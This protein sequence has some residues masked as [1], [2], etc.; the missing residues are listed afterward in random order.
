MKRFG[1]FFVAILLTLGLLFNQCSQQE[2]MNPVKEEVNIQGPEVNKYIKATGEKIEGSFIVVLKRGQFSKGEI[3][4]RARFLAESVGGEPTYIYTEALEGFAMRADQEAV[5]KLI[6]S[7]DVAFIEEDQV[8]HAFTTQNNAT[9][10]LDR[11]DQRNLPL[12]GTYVY[13]YTGSGVDV[14]VFD[15]GIR[16]S[17]SEFGGRA[18]AGYDAFGGNSYDQNGHGT[19]V[20]GTIGGRTYGVAKGVRLYAVRV[21]NAQGSGSISGIISGINWAINHHGSRPAVGNMS[22]GGGASTS[23]DNAVRNAINDGIVMCVAAG[24]ESQNAANVSP[25][26][27]SEAITVGATTSSDRFASYSNYGSV[28]DILAPGSSITS[29]WYTSDYAT[30]TISGTSMATPHV[31]GVAALYLQQNPSA[32]PAAVQSAIKNAASTGKISRVPYGT[33]NRLLYSLFNGGGGTPPPPSQE[34]YTG[35][36]SY[37]GDYDYQPN[38]SYYY[39]VGGTHKGVLDGPA[40]ADFDL[41]LYKWNGSRWSRVASSTSS[42]PDESIT[43]NGTAG[44]YFWYIYSYSGSGSYTFYLTRPSSSAKRQGE[45]NLTL[46]KN[47]PVEK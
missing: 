26:R 7:S 46:P 43:Y 45:E 41:Y 44:Y 25:A 37:S 1:V 12:N 14:Y 2:P 24:N 34:V 4:D 3:A 19:H 18:Y 31:A 40:G 16:L 9:W 27:V 42:G 17:H 29:A 10:G 39:A 6:Y 5:K 23:L 47:L 13:N 11:I 20:A 35:Y 38:G 28:V 30:N 33:T 36:L 21:L 15:T 32:S 8:V 22:L